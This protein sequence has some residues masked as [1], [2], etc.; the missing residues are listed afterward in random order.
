MT[1]R[2]E[3]VFDLPASKELPIAP[4]EEVISV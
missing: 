2:L 1:K 3:E 4:P